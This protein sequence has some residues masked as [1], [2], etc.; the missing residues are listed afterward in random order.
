MGAWLTEL[1]DE[2]YFVSPEEY[3]PERWTSKPDLVKNASVF[4]PFS[5]GRTKSLLHENPLI[6]STPLV[7]FVDGR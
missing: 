4:S 7:S 5:I 2:R 1:T 6:C 3:I